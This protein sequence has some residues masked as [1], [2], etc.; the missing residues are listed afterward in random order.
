MIIIFHYSE[1]KWCKQRYTLLYSNSRFMSHIK[2]QVK[3]L[4]CNIM[5]IPFNLTHVDNKYSNIYKYNNQT[6]Q[7]YHGFLFSSQLGRF[8]KSRLA[9]YLFLNIK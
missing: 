8:G 4:Y 7:K 2:S 6:E 1:Y 3:S 9:I 5:N